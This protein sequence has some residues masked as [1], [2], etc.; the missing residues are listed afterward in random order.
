MI[1]V[2]LSYLENLRTVY[3]IKSDIFNYWIMS[4]IFKLFAEYFVFFMGFLFIFVVGFL[5]AYI[6]PEGMLFNIIFLTIAIGWVIFMVKYFWEL[7][8]KNKFK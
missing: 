7:L 1:I 2:K 6:K 3:F 8:D 5:Y 4:K